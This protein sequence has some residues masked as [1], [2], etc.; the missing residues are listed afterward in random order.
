MNTLLQNW[1]QILVAALPYFMLGAIWYNPKFLGNTWASGHGWVMDE[2]K[3]KEVN[4]SKLFGLSFLCTIVLCAVVCYFCCV[5]Q[6]GKTLTEC[7]TAGLSVGIAASAAIS[8]NY[9]YLMKPLRVFVIDGSYHVLGCML[10]S[11]VYHLLGCC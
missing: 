1:W 5:G 7:L 4:M 10:A 3:R 2:A 11:S 6:M 9:I 8:M